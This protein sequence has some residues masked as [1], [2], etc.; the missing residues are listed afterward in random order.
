MEFNLT[1][2]LPSNWLHAFGATLF[3]SLWLG[4]LLSLLVAVIMFST[5]KAAASLRYNLLTGSLLL[6]V[7]ATTVI[8]CKSLGLQDGA[9]DTNLIVATANEPAQISPSV[10]VLQD[11]MLSGVNN[12]LEVWNA[13]AAQI[14]LVWFLI[15]CAKSIQLFVGLNGVYHL[16]STK[17]YAAGNR[18]DEKIGVLANR[19]GV[20][21][22]VSLLQSGIAQVPMAVGYFKPLVLIPLGLLNGLS[23]SEVEAILCHE[24]AHIKRRDYLINLLQSFVE[25][26]FFFNPA[27]LWV[28]K[29]IRNER[30]NCCDDLAVLHMD[31]KRNYVKALITCQEF[32]LNPPRFAM[33]ITG[34]KNHLFQRISRMLFDTKTTLNKMEKTILTI[35]LVS[36]VIGSAAF[37]NVTESNRKPISITSA[38]LQEQNFQDT[39]KKK[40]AIQ[41]AKKEKSVAKK[42]VNI[43]QLSME[44]EI[45][46]KQEQQANAIKA[47]MDAKEQDERYKQEQKR[48]DADQKRYNADQVRYKNEQK[49]YNA[50]QKRYD[51]EAKKYQAESDKYQ[52]QAKRYNANENYS[53]DANR[54]FNTLPP[55]TP[56]PPVPL[57]PVTATPMDPITP[58]TPVIPINAS[59]TVLNPVHVALPPAISIPKSNNQNRSN[60]KTTS[61]TG[62]QRTVESVT[63]TDADEHDYKNIIKDLLKDG[64]I[65]NDKK[66]SYKLD[67][68]SLII[69]DVRQNESYHQ[70]YKNKYLQRENTALL[71]KY[72]TNSN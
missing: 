4:I 17:V 70:K 25:I 7:I 64:I 69:N 41:K 8:F 53:N 6:F 12:L 29:L 39:L 19:M 56:I 31:D 35:A 66:L 10:A 71:Y 5:R 3:H 40:A 62:T 24:L 23:D 22:T 13:Y 2:F 68:N 72:E 58:I 32:Q 61:K 67:K 36:V 49:R 50:E 59:L 37:K 43:D 42:D 26:V 46:L 16:R 45:N 65:K 38:I 14:V 63:S 15:I 44:D 18:W 57:S 47:E 28:S 51:L 52:Q 30:E 48:Y 27:V 34:K 9:T 55:T 54:N 20:K 33:A 60:S 21:Q 1:R 11:N